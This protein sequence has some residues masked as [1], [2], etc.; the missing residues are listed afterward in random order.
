MTNWS[1]RKCRFYEWGCELHSWYG[2]GA[3]G[4][5]PNYKEDSD[6]I[7]RIIEQE[8]ERQFKERR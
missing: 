3:K 4:D 6:Y 1:C 5:C 2:D 8:V 7:K